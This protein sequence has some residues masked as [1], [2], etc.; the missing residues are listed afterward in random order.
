[1]FKSL[2]QKKWYKKT[3]K[4]CRTQ[5][6]MANGQLYQNRFSAPQMRL[7]PD[8]Y[9]LKISQSGEV[10]SSQVTHQTVITSAPYYTFTLKSVM[11]V[12][13]HIILKNPNG[14]IETN[15][16][17]RD[18]ATEALPSS[19]RELSRHSQLAT[20][21]YAALCAAKTRHT[22]T[23]TW[24]HHYTSAIVQK[25]FLHQ[26]AFNPLLNSLPCL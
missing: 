7:G 8:Y 18:W 12:R 5:Q 16:R 13:K 17:N 26:S 23:H 1:M 6:L 19:R 14:F 11:G 15:E 20:C 2:L 10:G 21:H 25:G 3:Q 24:L 4:H 22:L 9:R